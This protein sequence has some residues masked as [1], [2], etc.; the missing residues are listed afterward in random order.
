MRWFTNLHALPKLVLSFGL[1][2][3]LN[4][5]TGI[6]ALSR[7]NEESD[8]V[9]TAYSRDIEGMAQVDSVASAKLGLARLTRDAILKIDNKDAVAKDVAA[10][11]A[12]ATATRKDIEE[13]QT[14]FK[15]EEGAAQIAEI[16]QLFPHYVQLCQD[17]LSRVQAGDAAGAV[18]ALAAVEPV[19]KVLNNDTAEAAA[20]KRRRAVRTSAMSQSSYR[21]VRTLLVSMI[22]ACVLAGVGMSFWIGKLISDP[23]RKAVSLLRN[24]AEG[25][26]TGKLELDTH[27]EVGE[28]AGALNEAIMKMRDALQEVTAASVGVDTA[29]RELTSSSELIADGAQKQ[30]ASLEET[31]A[32]LE[33][34]TATVRQ[35]ADNAREAS[36]LASSSRESAEQGGHIV[37]GAVDAMGEINVASKKISDIISTVDEI[38]FQTNLLAV[39][40]AVE[41]ARAGEQGRGFAVVATE[42]RSLAL[43]SAASAKEIKTLIGDTLQKVNKGTNLVNRSGETLQSIIQSVKRVSEIVGDIAIASREQSTGIEQ[44][45]LAMG[46]MDGVTQ[47]NSAQTKDLAGTAGALSGQSATLIALVGKFRIDASAPANFHQQEMDS[48]PTRSED[49]YGMGFA[50]HRTAGQVF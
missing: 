7:L 15:G 12:L 11:D 29:S 2:T 19:A 13:S 41:A 40:A 49:R 9:V 17:I 6:L 24:V 20:A 28:M 36:V 3:L 39:N 45:N 23:L 37:S 14:A 31:A 34:I 18:D 26:L 10:F 30:A 47:T 44:V 8:R 48:E 42:V 38:A 22:A 50:A 46:Q 25:D 35:S 1:L 32:S 5:M 16:A 27:D 21:T 4:A 33:Q 43:R